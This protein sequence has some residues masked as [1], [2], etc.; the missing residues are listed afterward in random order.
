M[1]IFEFDKTVDYD[2]LE[3]GKHGDIDHRDRRPPRDS[4]RPASSFARQPLAG[5]ENTLSVRAEKK[6]LK[7]HVLDLG[8]LRLDK[9]FI[10]ANSTVAT[11]RNPNPRSQIIDIPVAAYYIEHPDG[12]ILYDTGCHP[13]WAGPKGRW[14][15]ALQELFPHVGGEECML[16]ARLDAMG[17]GP[18]QIRHV[19]LSHLHCDHAGCVEYFRKSQIIVHEDEF[20]GAFRQYALNDHSSPY[21]LKD[22]DKMI[23]A[24]LNWREIG[25]YEPDQNIVD[26]VRLLNFGPG[27]ARGM[28]GLQV[29]LRSQ[30]GVILVSDACY[31]AENY[32]PPAKPPGISYDTV[33]IS[34]TVQRIRALAGDSGHT[35]WYGHDAG[36]FATLRKASEG[37]YE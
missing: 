19:V 22:L 10:V 26:G 15:D 2:L 9:N 32:G 21:V 31:T 4:S 12:T 36:Q 30:P 25:R 7:M 35:V 34:R 33:G 11:H 24:E 18:D 20:A 1:K 17:I 14:P 29:S 5:S 8:I 23:R 6:S 28:L 13:D 27:H 37:Y 3:P 16:P